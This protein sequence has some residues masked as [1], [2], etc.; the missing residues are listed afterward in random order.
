MIR[1]SKPLLTA[2]PHACSEQ[3]RADIECG[4]A[5]S[6]STYGTQIGIVDHDK[7]YVWNKEE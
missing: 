2:L 5:V 4:D 3:G 7:V 6:L 1:R